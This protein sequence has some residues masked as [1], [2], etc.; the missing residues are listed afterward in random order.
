MKCNRKPTN[1][2]GNA[3][4]RARRKLKPLRVGFLP[5]NDCAPVVMAHEFGWFEQN[6]LKV[7]LRSEASWKHIHDKFHLGLLDAAHAPASLPF[8]MNVGL[9]P[10]KHACVTGLVLS[11]EGNAITVS[12]NLSRLG[13]V[14]AATMGEHVFKERGR[15]SY[16]FGVACPLSPQYFLLCQWLKA[17]NLPHSAVRIE[18][19]PSEQ[20]FPLLKLGYL[21]GYCAGEP[22]GSV[23][24]QAGVGECVATSAQLAPLHPE[25]V[26]MVRKDFAESRAEEHELLL[27]AL[28]HACYR[29]DQPAD[30]PAI[31][32]KLAQA[33][34]VNAPADC[35]APGLVG[36]AAEMAGQGREPRAANVFYRMRANEPSA[37][38]AAWVTGQL[39]EFLRW[40]PRPAG[41]DGVFRPDI[42]RRARRL[43][44]SELNDGPRAPRI[45]P[46]LAAKSSGPLLACGA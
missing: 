29:C 18:S 46:K 42:Y 45:Q 16:T 20:L 39:Y 25:K 23:A 43:V 12:R 2:L 21:D 37:A 31:C 38:K 7:E 9:T 10:E 36:P 35:L 11:L 30:R 1:L 26:L 19:A 6:G 8:L 22:W 28:I 17:A 14:D 32:D 41:L 27:A 4:S 40:A 15:R 3:A 34:Y 33:R 5:E 13:V 44:S 24:V